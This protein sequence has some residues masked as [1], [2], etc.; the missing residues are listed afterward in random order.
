MFS[1]EFKEQLGKVHYAIR[2]I[3]EDRH[4]NIRDGLSVNAVLMFLDFI[5]AEEAEEEL[6]SR[7]E[8]TEEDRSSE[9]PTCNGEGV[10]D[11]DEYEGTYYCQC[12]GMCQE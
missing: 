3:Y 2:S 6:Y 8:N 11:C 12:G 7:R 5:E 4:G 10:L 9:C 1:I